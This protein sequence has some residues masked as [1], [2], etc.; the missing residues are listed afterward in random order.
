MVWTH[1]W[2]MHSGGDQKLDWSNIY[3]EA[4]E[5]EARS[6]FYARFKRNPERVT[7]TCCGEDYA[8]SEHP[9][10]EE[11]TAYQR[12]D[13]EYHKPT[14][15]GTTLA[16]YRKRSDVHI[17]DEEHIVDGER[18]TSVPDEGYTWSGGQ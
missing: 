6:I 11:A 10:L 9:S 12:E 7:C 1:F 15:S 14:G 8:I 3:I 17:I 5:A 16:E 18:Q 4:P 13:T 2:D